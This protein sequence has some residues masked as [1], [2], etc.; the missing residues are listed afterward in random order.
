MYRILPDQL[1]AIRRR[2]GLVVIGYAA[3]CPS[4]FHGMPPDFAVRFSRKPLIG[5]MQDELKIACHFAILELKANVPLPVTPLLETEIRDG[6]H[7]LRETEVAFPDD[8][9]A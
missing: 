9:S 3:R 8:Y 1:T 2:F 4:D 6:R 7:L 5:L